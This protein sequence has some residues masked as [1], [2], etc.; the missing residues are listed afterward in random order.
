MASGTDGKI[1][2]VHFGAGRAGQRSKGP[3]R[4]ERRRAKGD[5][6]PAP[7]AEPA[8]ESAP[9]QVEPTRDVYTRAEVEKLTG[10]SAS[11][12]RALER[13]GV[14]VPSVRR[15]ARRAYTFQDLI[16]LRAALGL[17]GRGVKVRDVVR[18]V[19]A[20]RTALPRIKKPLTELKVTGD[21]SR[22]IVRSS[23]GTFEPTTGQMTLDFDV[24]QLRDDVVRVLRP[25]V[26]QHRQ[27]AAFEIYKRASELDEDP[28]TMDEAARLY[29]QAIDT[30]PLLAIA[31]TNL[32]NILFR[33]GDEVAAEALYSKAL[34]LDARQP[35]AKYNLGY[36][37]LERHELDL[38]IRYFQGAIEA[39]PRFADAYFNLA[40]AY[41]EL[42]DR[43]NARP[44][45]RT[46]LELEPT[47]TWADIARQHLG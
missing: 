8:A 25:A 28:R 6:P 11:R 27:R 12:L 31:Y 14:V 23:E 33:K 42:G 32:G 45:W 4:Q 18:A 13:N 29:R 9:P 46:Y 16:A 22:V 37:M 41:E 43:R 20:L 24:K 10:A 44:L 7:V 47:G 26:K 36:L 5:V 15:G 3:T 21:G 39:D 34:A 40:M 30:D 2:H 17:L 35:E 19:A 1:I 38:A